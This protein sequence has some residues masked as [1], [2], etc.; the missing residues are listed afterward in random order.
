MTLSMVIWVIKW[1]SKPGSLEGEKRRHYYEVVM[2]M[3]RESVEDTRGLLLSFCWSTSCWL[4]DGE[5][6]LPLM[7]RSGSVPFLHHL[8]NH[9]LSPLWQQFFLPQKNTLWV[10]VPSCCVSGDHSVDGRIFLFTEWPWYI[11]S[12]IRSLFYWKFFFSSTWEIVLIKVVSLKI[13]K[14]IFFY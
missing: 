7:W 3:L 10:I 4:G 9:L 2:W 5:I 12:E 14:S 6:S 8:A 1:I 13:I 11:L